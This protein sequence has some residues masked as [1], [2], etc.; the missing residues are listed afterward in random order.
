MLSSLPLCLLHLPQPQAARQLA[1]L[2]SILQHAPEASSNPWALLELAVVPLP[3]PAGAP[4]HKQ[5]RLQQPQRRTAA[6]A[7][8][9]FRRLAAA[10]HPDKCAERAWELSAGA[11]FLALSDARDAAV[12]M[13]RG[14]AR[15]PG[16]G[17]DGDGHG[18]GGGG[19][20][21]GDPM[22]W[23]L[24]EGGAGFRRG[25]D[26]DEADAAW[27]AAWDKDAGGDGGGG[28]GGGP[29]GFP[30]TE[31]R[32][33]DWDDEA[34]ALRALDLAA[35]RTEVARRQAAVLAP[36]TDEERA[37]PPA[38]RQRRLRVARGALSA[39]L[40]EAA[41]A[42]DS[43]GG[44]EGR[45]WGDGGSGGGFVPEGPGEATIPRKKL[46]VQGWEMVM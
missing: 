10:A 30:S 42:G 9:L 6:H 39:R 24:G 22:D 32:E 3:A 13:A 23:D 1:L 12:R 33:E 2:A 27:W 20:A 41:A 35:L 46:R 38:A 37:L 40:E 19:G 36:A 43:C 45:A 28:D 11:A 25:A 4:R 34:Q 26:E 44:E 29:Q 5:Q 17:S 8:R 14:G 15:S 18:V 31:P 16:G 21:R 7:A